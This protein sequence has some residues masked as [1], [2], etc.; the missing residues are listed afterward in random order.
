MGEFNQLVNFWFAPVE[1]AIGESSLVT[2][3]EFMVG[4]LL[5]RFLEVAISCCEVCSEFL[6]GFLLRGMVPCV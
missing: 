1:L 4:S 6:R 3:G 5:R 2:G